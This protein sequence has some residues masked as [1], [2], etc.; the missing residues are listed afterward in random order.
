MMEKNGMLSLTAE[1]MAEYRKG[2]VPK[3]VEED[4]ELDF[5]SLDGMVKSGS[6]EVIGDNENKQDS[7]E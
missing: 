1:E 2:R 5:T 7:P 4:W 3:R 6:V